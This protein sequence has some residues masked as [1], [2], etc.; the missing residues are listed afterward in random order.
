[1]TIGLNEK[2]DMDVV[3]FKK[4]ILHLIVPLFSNTK[5]VKGNG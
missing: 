4:Y 5:F 1:M 3:E 2:G